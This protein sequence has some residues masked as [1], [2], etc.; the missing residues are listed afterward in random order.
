L[1][2][3]SIAG[4][5]YEPSARFDLNDNAAVIDHSGAS[6]IS[7]VRWQIYAG[8][9][10]YGLGGTWNGQGITSSAA[11]A[12]NAVEPEARSLGFAENAG[13]PLGP[14]TSFHGQPV[15]LTSVLIAFTRTG[16]ANLDG[17]VNDD[18]VTVVGAYYAPG[19][20]NGH[21]S[22]GDFD[23]NGF[24]DDNDVTLLGAFYNPA[25]QPLAA[26]PAAASATAPT[27][28]ASVPEPVGLT[29]LLFGGGILLVGAATSARRSRVALRAAAG[30]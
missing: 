22:L 26:S 9:G 6:P 21:W 4:A 25:A 8:R 3:L 19:V 24:V 5:A 12:A 10:G 30:R 29:L 13:L 1:G 18:D 28:V 20:H 7:D 17:V 14:Y 27:A 15:D 23:Y 16:D 11:A 2:A